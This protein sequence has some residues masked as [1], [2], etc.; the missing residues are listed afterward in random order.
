MEPE[1]LTRFS[2]RGAR[3]L[4]HQP[5]APGWAADASRVMWAVAVR[6]LVRLGPHGCGWRGQERYGRS[7]SMDDTRR[8]AEQDDIDEQQLKRRYYERLSDWSD[9]PVKINRNGKLVK[10][11]VDSPPRPESDA[12][13]NWPKR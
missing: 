8:M 6:H 3:L 10:P 7:S 1:T 4:R 2:G 9:E 13:L 12:V 11:P 5:R